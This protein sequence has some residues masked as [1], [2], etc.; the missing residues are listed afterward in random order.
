[1]SAL[2]HFCPQSQVSSI[3]YVG[4]H[5]PEDVET[6][7]AELSSKGAYESCLRFYIDL[8]EVTSCKLEKAGMRQLQHSLARFARTRHNPDNMP[9]LMAYFAPTSPAQQVGRICTGQWNLNPDFISMTS[10]L[11]SDCAVFL[12]M[13]L[14]HLNA[15]DR[16][17]YVRLGQ[18]RNGA[19]AEL[20]VN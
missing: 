6:V 4:V 16:S 1:M 20:Q 2:L 3:R 17:D 8:S 14:S 12:N 19:G 10:D 7:L 15:A 5:T 13:K 18:Y 11:Q 9:L